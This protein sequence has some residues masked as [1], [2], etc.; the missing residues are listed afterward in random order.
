MKMIASVLALTALVAPP[1]NGSNG[2]LK[3]VKDDKYRP[4]QVWL[5]QTRPNEKFSTLTILRVEEA[6]EKRIVHIRVDHILLS[7]CKGG[8]EPEQLAHMPFD[9]GAIDRSVVKSL[10]VGRVPDYQAGY[11]EWR[12][13]W[14]KGRAGVYTITVAEAL[15]VAEKTFHS[16]IGC[17]V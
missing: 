9:K 16:G 3:E 15:D 4:G 13:G 2:T 12:A 7:N 11:S 10:L 8:P 5:Y 14:D 17:P 1:I 6:G